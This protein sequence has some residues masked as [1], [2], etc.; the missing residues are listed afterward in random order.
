MQQTKILTIKSNYS[1]PIEI[2]QLK[3]NDPRID[4]RMLNKEVK[5]WN[6]SIN[7]MITFDAGKTG[8]EMQS[9]YINAI[10]QFSIDNPPTLQIDAFN[11]QK[12]QSKKNSKMDGS[13][14]YSK[15]KSLSDKDIL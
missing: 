2:T 3:A 4:T 11:L 9:D 6:M 7:G 10:S 5:P 15:F 14:I 13:D 8:M 12:M 1:N